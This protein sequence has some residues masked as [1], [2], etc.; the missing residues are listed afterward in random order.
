MAKLGARDDSPGSE[1]ATPQLEPKAIPEARVA[2]AG[3]FSRNKERITWDT[4]SIHS[5]VKPIDTY[6]GLHRWDPEFQW[7]KKEE[8]RVVRKVRS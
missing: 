8:Q 5:H 2:D 4:T 6:E 7:D 1:P 3:L